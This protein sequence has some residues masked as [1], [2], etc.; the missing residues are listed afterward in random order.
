MWK[1]GWLTS[2]EKASDQSDELRGSWSG[3][4][5]VEEDAEIHVCEKREEE[6]TG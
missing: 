6:G 3:F 4:L 1:E 5:P 2:L